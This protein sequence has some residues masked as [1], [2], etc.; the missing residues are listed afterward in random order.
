MNPYIAIAGL[1][2]LGAVF[3]LVMVAL[4]LLFSPTRKNRAKHETYECGIDPT[5]QAQGGGRFP[6]KYYVIAMLY[7]IFDIEIVFLY[8]WAV[9]FNQL[10]LF[11]VVEMLLFMLT[12]F[13]A[14]IYVYR[15]GGLDWD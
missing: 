2:G 11:A 3:V 13:I 10:G 1:A 4:N 9:S 12:I 14:Y 15:R 7:I 5:P 6:V 8:P